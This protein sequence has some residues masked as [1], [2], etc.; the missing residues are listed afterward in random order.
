MRRPRPVCR[1]PIRLLAAIF[2][3]ALVAA[4]VPAAGADAVE[5]VEITVSDLDRSVEFFTKVLHF[6]HLSEAE[7]SAPEYGRL[8]G[9]DGARIRTARLALGDERVDLT[10][11]LAPKGR[12]VPADS[13]SNDR[14]FQHIAIIVSD[15]DSAYA[16]LR[17]HRVTHVSSGPQTLPEWNENAAGI[18]AFYFR[19]PDGHALEILQFPPG[20]GDPKWHEPSDRLFLGIDHTAIVVSDTEAS[21]RLYRDALGARVVGTSENHGTEQERLNAVFGARLVITGLRMAS[22][23]GIEFLE[24]LAPPGGRPAPADLAPNDLSHWQTRIH[25]ANVETAI[26]RVL[27]EGGRL[28]SADRPVSF[29]DDRLGFRA[30]ALV[31]DPDGH[32]LL[33]AGPPDSTGPGAL[34]AASATDSPTE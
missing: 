7:T 8:Q 34:G 6:E 4:P 24:Y 2:L 26:G 30:A 15:M 17:S 12:P 3:W 11:Y 22:G 5:S 18:R 9:I 14:W 19:D 28:V 1:R 32:A 10:E 23:P 27:E 16:W 25:L 31:R 13:R 20:K 33:L 21:L 29:T